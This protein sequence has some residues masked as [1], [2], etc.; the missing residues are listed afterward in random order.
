MTR[1]EKTQLRTSPEPTPTRMALQAECS[2]QLVTVTFSHGIGRSPSG[3][4]FPRRVM[5]SSPERIWHES[6]VTSRQQSMSIPSPLG[7]SSG[8]KTRSPRAVTCSQAWK[9]SVQ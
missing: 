5:L 1:L 9:K 3:F 4:A 8:L 6:T 7:V 2:V